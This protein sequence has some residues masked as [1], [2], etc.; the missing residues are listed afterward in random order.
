MPQVWWCTLRTRGETQAW[1]ST[2]LHLVAV[3]IRP[4]GRVQLFRG[5]HSHLWSVE[6]I[7]HGKRDRVAQDD[8]YHFVVPVLPLYHPDD[9]L[10]EGVLQRKEEKRPLIIETVVGPRARPLL[11]LTPPSAALCQHQQ[12][13]PAAQGSRCIRR[14]VVRRLCPFRRLQHRPIV[15]R[16][17][18]R[19]FITS[20][21]HT[22]QTCH[23]MQPRSVLV[24]H[25]SPNRTRQCLCPFRRLQHRPI[26]R[27]TA[28]RWFI[29]SVSH[30]LQTCH[31]MQPRSVLVR[32]LS[33]NRTRQCH[34]VLCPSRFPPSSHP[35]LHTRAAFY[36]SAFYT[37]PR[38]AR[39]VQG[40]PAL[41]VATHTGATTHA[42]AVGRNRSAAVGRRRRPPQSPFPLVT[43]YEIILESLEFGVRISAE[44]RIVAFLLAC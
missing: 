33:P 16:T 12:R 8:S 29:T 20:V 40:T 7:I 38:R 23:F 11:S 4:G 26:V 31:F 5:A 18:D 36:A 30:T 39:R 6:A 17:A 21:S 43:L 13:A 32:H 44:S 27:K 42:A 41:R 22:L 37:R 2:S 25:L 10:P 34:T 3:A 15:R 14:G 24:R 35:G 19:W 28:D 9:R 1:G